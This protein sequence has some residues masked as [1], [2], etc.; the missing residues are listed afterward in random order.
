LLFISELK[1]ESSDDDGDDI[2]A[3]DHVNNGFN[4][5]AELRIKLGPASYQPISAGSFYFHSCAW[6]ITQSPQPNESF[7]IAD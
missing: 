7:Q 2:D 4:A 3:D 1:G 5:A 6:R